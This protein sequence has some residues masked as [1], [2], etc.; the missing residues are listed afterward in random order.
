MQ[1][2]L[3]NIMGTMVRKC[4]CSSVQKAG[5]FTI[6]ADETKDCGKKEQVLHY[7][8]VE[9]AELFEHFLTYV[10]ATSLDVGSLSVD[11]LRT[12]GLDPQSNVS[13][14]YDGASVKSGRCTGVQQRICEVVP[15]ATYVHCYA[16]RL[17]LVLVD[18]MRIVPEA[19][20]FFSLMEVLH[21]CQEVFA[22]Q[23]DRLNCIQTNPQRQL[24]RLSDPRW[25]C[26]YL[27]VE[28]VCRT[29]GSVLATLEEL[30]NGEDRSRAVEATGILTEV[31]TFKFYFH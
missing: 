27:A 22:M 7:V 16:H 14:G 18:S 30:A 17:N 2:S 25:C 13:Q 11:A 31:Q 9:A 1:N 8:N 29:F 12:N 10:Q 3:I 4:I 15:H 5:A 26:R 24:Q 21:F 6:L 20:E 23:G 28:A 19:S